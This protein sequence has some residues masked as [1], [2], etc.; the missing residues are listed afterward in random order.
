MPYTHSIERAFKSRIGEGGVDDQAFARLLAHAEEEVE[1]LRKA[2]SNGTLPLLRLPEKTDD[3]SALRQAVKKL[4]RASDIVFLGT[5]GS[6]LGGQTLAQQPA[7]EEG[8]ILAKK[9]L[10]GK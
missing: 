3:L 4:A 9:Y 7:L 8:K 5:G 6:S 10:S 1:N 2:H